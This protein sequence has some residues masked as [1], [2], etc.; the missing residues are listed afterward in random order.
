[1]EGLVADI[2]PNNVKEL[3][4]GFDLILDGTDNFET[5]F[6]TNDFAIRADCPWIYGAAVASYGLTMTVRPGVTAC[7]ACLMDGAEPN[8]GMGRPSTSSPHCRPPKR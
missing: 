6:L 7:L 5:R 1:V 3:L 4:D 8:S 2:N